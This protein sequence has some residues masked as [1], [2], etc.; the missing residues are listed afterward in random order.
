MKNLI[1]LRAY[2][3]SYS[4]AINPDHIINFYE[5]EEDKNNCIIKLLNEDHF[6]AKIAFYDLVELINKSYE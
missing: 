3:N 1:V 4:L 5:D 6:A 2:D